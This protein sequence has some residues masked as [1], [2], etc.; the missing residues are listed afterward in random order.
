MV[1]GSNFG[2]LQKELRLD[3]PLGTTVCRSACIL[4]PI[5]ARNEINEMDIITHKILQRIAQNW[6]EVPLGDRLSLPATELAAS[7]LTSVTPHLMHLFLHFDS[8][9][10]LCA[11]N[12]IETDAGFWQGPRPMCARYLYV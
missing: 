9:G 10:A 11:N 2:S 1:N 6:K 4:I 7:R 5:S 3:Y 8:D 12:F